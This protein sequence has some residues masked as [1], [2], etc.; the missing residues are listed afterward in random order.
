[1]EDVL[2]PGIVGIAGRRDAVAPADI[3]AQALAAPVG[4]VEGGIGED[5]VGLQVREGV[6]VEAALVVPADVGVD[7]PHGKV[8]PGQPPGGVVALLAVDGD[9]A[10]APA[11]LG[12]ELFGLDEH[13][14]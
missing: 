14:P 13:A 5:E 6:L 1:M 7:A 3:L 10:D 9:V 11:M 8:H 2:E 12:D 4:D